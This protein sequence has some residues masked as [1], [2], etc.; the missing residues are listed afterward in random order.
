M[1][2][3]VPEVGQREASGLMNLFVMP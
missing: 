2:V 3:H 1:S